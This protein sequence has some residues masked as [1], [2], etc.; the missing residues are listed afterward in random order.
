M[1]EIRIHGRGGQGVKTAAQFIA[2]AALAQGKFIQAFPEYGPERTGAPVKAYVRINHNPIRLYTP[3]NTPSIVLVM[4]PTLFE[5]ENVI[6]GL[7]KDGILIV[8]SPKSPREIKNK[9][10][11]D[12]KVCTVDGTTI[13]LSTIGR[14]TSNT[15]LLGALAKATNIISLNLVKDFI[16]NHFARKVDEK[17]AEANAEAINQGY[18]QAKILN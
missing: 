4:D 11:F 18:Q 16:K 14:N 3:I 10:D 8:N 5:V 1:L 6:L 17:M 12:G 2:E 13:A 9:I 7:K 15:V